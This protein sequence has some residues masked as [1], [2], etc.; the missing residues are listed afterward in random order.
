[1]IESIRLLSNF[2]ASWS[3]TTLGGGRDN[4]SISRC[5]VFSGCGGGKLI[6]L[7]ESRG[8]I[9]ESFWGEK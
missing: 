6:L 8:T 5:S 2:F 1:M 9:A 4:I 3:G 7:K